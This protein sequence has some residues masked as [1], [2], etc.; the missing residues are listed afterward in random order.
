MSRT[1]M[2]YS[3]VIEPIESTVIAGSE[4]YRNIHGDIDK[5][6]GSRVQK[7]VGTGTDSV[8]DSGSNQAIDSSSDTV[9]TGVSDHVT[10]ISSVTTT[11]GL[12]I[13]DV[14]YYSKNMGT[15]NALFIAILSAGSTGTPDVLMSIDGTNYE[16]SLSGAGDWMMIPLKSIDAANVKLKSSGATTVANVDIVVGREV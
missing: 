12:S 3:V 1:K 8:V 2:N 9:V 5:A 13:E 6:V 10:Y 4:A 11:S 15:L 16:Y 14:Q 7:S